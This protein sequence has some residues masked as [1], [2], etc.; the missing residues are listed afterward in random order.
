MMRSR[1]LTAIAA[2]AAAL[3]APLVATAQTYPAKAIRIIVPN[4]TGSGTDIGARRLAGKLTTS[5]GQSV[6]VEDIPGAGG[7]IGAQALLQAPHD[8]YTLGVVSSSHVILPHLYKSLR[9]DVQ[10]DFVPIAWVNEAPLILV[11]RPEFAA[12][13]IRQ[14]KEL[15]SSSIVT[16]GSGGNG[17]ITHLCALQLQRLGGFKLSHIPYKGSGAN[18]PDI[19]SG[20]VDIGIFAV[21]TV[22]TL[23][24]DGKLKPLAIT[25]AVRVAALPSVPTIAETVPGYDVTSWSALIAPAGVPASVIRRLNAETVR[26]TSDPDWKAWSVSTGGD[27]RSYSV[28]EAARVYAREYESSGMLIREAG[29]KMD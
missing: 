23:I 17:S 27:T 29:L 14:L 1:R 19:V 18:I 6:F 26:I 11:A 24:A 7:A 15:A 13:N 21:T 25:G 16:F 10:K 9:F 20:V 8:G 28:E 5:L 22:Q 2:L 4:T 3:L 12:S